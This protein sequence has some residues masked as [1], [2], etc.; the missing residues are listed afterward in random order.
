M[1]CPQGDDGG[2]GLQIRTVDV[3][4]LNMQSLTVDNGQFSSMDKGWR[5]NNSMP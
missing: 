4:I 2:D 5:A 1:A 3:N